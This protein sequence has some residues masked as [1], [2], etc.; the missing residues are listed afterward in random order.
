M[1]K[2]S[3]TLNGNN[4]TVPD[5]QTFRPNLPDDS[6]I[7][8]N[9]HNQVMPPP[10][11]VDKNVS[12]ATDHQLSPDSINGLDVYKH[13]GNDADLPE[14]MKPATNLRAM[15]S[16]EWNEKKPSNFSIKIEKNGPDTR[17]VVSQD[18]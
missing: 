14:R 4:E 7:T 9:D 6:Q 8:N 1:H 16:L 10:K 11:T 2:T 15:V 17:F 13:N 18:G 12:D 3:A 5:A